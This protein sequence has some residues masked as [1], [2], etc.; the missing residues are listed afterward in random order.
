MVYQLEGKQCNYTLDAAS[1][2]DA[3]QGTH[4]LLISYEM[5]KKRLP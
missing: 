4:M 3:F 1:T 5:L 2:G